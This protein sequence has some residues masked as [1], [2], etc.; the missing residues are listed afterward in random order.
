MH[1]L[2]I[3]AVFF[4]DKKSVRPKVVICIL[5]GVLVGLTWLKTYYNII[6]RINL[7][8]KNGAPESRRN[9]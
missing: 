5:D 9:S 3:L 6:I 7:Q 2:F 8:A 4:G 1:V